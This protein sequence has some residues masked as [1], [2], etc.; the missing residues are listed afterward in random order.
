VGKGCGEVKAVY[1]F[2]A[3]RCGLALKVGKNL[4]RF[5]LTGMFFLHAFILLREMRGKNLFFLG[6]IDEKT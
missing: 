1:P 4:F 5:S 3:M 2:S 6:G